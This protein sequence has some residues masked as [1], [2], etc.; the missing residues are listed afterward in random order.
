MLSKTR[1]H[2]VSAGLF[3]AGSLLLTNANAGL[4]GFV[5]DPCTAA[6][7][8]TCIG[9]DDSNTSTLLPLSYITDASFLTGAIANSNFKTT[10]N[11]KFDF[12][13]NLIPEGDLKVSTYT[14]WA[15]NNTPPKDPN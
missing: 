8:V 15:V 14:A 7:T 5:N 9:P 11:W 2:I 12:S 3:A 13:T 1:I 6:P 4:I 10:D